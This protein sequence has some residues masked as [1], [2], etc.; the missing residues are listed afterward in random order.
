LRDWTTDASLDADTRYSRIVRFA[1][2][3]GA[4]LWLL[5]VLTRLFG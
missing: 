5:N 2:H 4:P 1:Y 3:H